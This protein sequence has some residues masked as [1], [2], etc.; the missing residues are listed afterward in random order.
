VMVRHAGEAADQAW[1]GPGRHR[2]RDL[3][4]ESEAS[5]F[6]LYG[7][8]SEDEAMREGR[9]SSTSAKDG[10]LVQAETSA[11]A[12]EATTA[13]P[14][15]SAK[16][17]PLVQAGYS[18]SAP[19]D[20][21]TDSGSSIKDGPAVGSSAKNGP[22]EREAVSVQSKGS[23]RQHCCLGPGLPRFEDAPSPSPHGPQWAPQNFIEEGNNQ[24]DVRRRNIIEEE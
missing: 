2:R 14:G 15:T 12:S 23:G 5:L 3:L 4:R 7:D 1:P 11:S 19:A 13:G 21:A 18:A 9:G 10:F 20:R 24:L 6:N 8:S 16:D 22:Q 17:A